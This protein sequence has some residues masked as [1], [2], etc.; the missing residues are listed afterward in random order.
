MDL[1]FILY[2]KAFVDNI[3]EKFYYAS[4]MTILAKD[5][6]GGRRYLTQ[7]NVLIEVAP[8]SYKDD[9]PRRDS[10]GNVLVW[11][12]N[13]RGEADKSILRQIPGSYP[14]IDP[15]PPETKQKPDS[16]RKRG[17]PKHE[18]TPWRGWAYEKPEMCEAIISE[19]IAQGCYLKHSKNYISVGWGGRKVFVMFRNGV[20]G[21]N[22]IPKYFESYRTKQMTSCRF[23]Q[24]HMELRRVLAD[25][26]R[27]NL[28]KD[29]RQY[30]SD[31]KAATAVPSTRLYVP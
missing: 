1:T 14:L 18:N 9:S 24:Y 7:K 6:R 20:I 16:P 10:Q 29:F 11:I 13:D 21:F 23:C 27:E 30:I 17:R 31:V 25:G 8:R 15:N 2:A 4:M 22:K 19:A 3:V 5:S 12:V 28:I 26:M